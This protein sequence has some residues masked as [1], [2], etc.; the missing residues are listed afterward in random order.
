MRDGKLQRIYS[1]NETALK[2]VLGPFA[3]SDDLIFREKDSSKISEQQIT[4]KKSEN[5]RLT[6]H[7][8]LMRGGVTSMMLVLFSAH[9]YSSC[10]SQTTRTIL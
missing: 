3:E 6:I 8:C 4:L 1:W 7:H 10:I 2:S 9:P 5:K